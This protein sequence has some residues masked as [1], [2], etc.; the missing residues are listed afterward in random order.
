MVIWLIAA[1]VGAA[2]AS[3]VVTRWLVPRLA[4]RSVF[5]IPNQRSS[6]T[7]ATVR[8]AGV[9]LAVTWGL[10]FLL[11]IILLRPS[12]LAGGLTILG[13]AIGL[14]VVGFWDDLRRLSPGVRLLAQVVLC[15][16][17]AVLG[18]RTESLTFPGLP[19]LHLGS[20][21]IAISAIGL[22]TMVNFFNFMD[23]IDGLAI[24]QTLVAAI[25]LLAGAIVVHA[26]TIAVLAACLAGVAAGFL[27][28]NWSPARCFMG[29]SGSYFCGGTLGALLILGE[30]SGIPLLL[31]GLASAP[32]LADSAITLVVRLA[33]GKRIW[34]AHHSHVY[35]R[36]VST[37][38]SHAQVAGLYIAVAAST[39]TAAILY[40]ARSHAVP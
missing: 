7:T 34:Q 38:W 40:L 33:R 27:P 3:N 18:V 12:G 35:Q 25:V 11:V 10:C 32:F 1:G 29:D 14:S 39:G 16:A 37:G 20:L 13:L 2:L 23:G 15:S 6:H 8:G 26:F 4:A 22:L 28:F 31:V 9:A 19:V 24:G 5:D 30:Q 17:A 36:L 21:A